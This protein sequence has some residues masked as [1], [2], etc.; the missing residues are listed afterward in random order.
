MV[1][2]VYTY[3]NGDVYRG[4]W[5]HDEKNGIGRQTFAN[6][7][8]HQQDG[9]AASGA[10]WYDGHWKDGRIEGKGELLCRNGISY[11]GLDFFTLSARLTS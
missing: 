4:D 7:G 8:S 9:D 3:A 2:G 10:E 5:K 11:P 1:Q 6:A